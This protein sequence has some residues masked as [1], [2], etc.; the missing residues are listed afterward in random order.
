MVNRARRGSES[1]S[2]VGGTPCAATSGPAILLTILFTQSPVL[3]R[4]AFKSLFRFE[5]LSAPSHTLGITSPVKTSFFGKTE[6]IR[7]EVVAP[8]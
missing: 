7:M 2:G 5:L 1:S 6:C 4:F 8:L 3:S